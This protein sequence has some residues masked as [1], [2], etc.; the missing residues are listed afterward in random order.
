MCLQSS[1]SH[2]DFSSKFH[3]NPLAT[4]KQSR[5]LS[6]PL[7][8]AMSVMVFALSMSLRWSI[9]TLRSL[10]ENKSRLGTRKLH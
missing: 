10:A 5:T 1:Q 3:K 9:F 8:L 4:P 2:Q 7:T 6:Q